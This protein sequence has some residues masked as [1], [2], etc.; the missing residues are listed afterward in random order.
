MSRHAPRTEMSDEHAAAE[1]ARSAVLARL[2]SGPYGYE[3]YQETRAKLSSARGAF[4]DLLERL[5]PMDA[6]NDEGD[7]LAGVGA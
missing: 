1:Q 4:A 6:G 3:T 7:H 5:G 2:Q